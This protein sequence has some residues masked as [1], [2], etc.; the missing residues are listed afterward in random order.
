MALLLL[1]TDAPGCRDVVAHEVDGLLVPLRN[2]SALASAI[3]RLD[4]N[5]ELCEHFGLAAREKARIEF[6][7]KRVIAE[8]IA[9]YYE[10]LA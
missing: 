3:A 7:E 5:P 4:D 6:D 8:T 1:P 9:V 2:A 10:V